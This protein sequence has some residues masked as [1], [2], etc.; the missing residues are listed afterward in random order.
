MAAYRKAKGHGWL[1][2]LMFAIGLGVGIAFAT[3]LPNDSG[4]WPFV[5][6]SLSIL[7]G[8]IA[9]AVMQSRIDKNRR[10]SLCSVLQGLGMTALISPSPQE[11]A[12][13]F[14]QL[15]HLETTAG[16]QSGSA[17]LQWIAYGTIG[18][19]VA[20]AFEHEYL[21]GSGEYTQTHIATCIAWVGAP[22][23]LTLIRPR[24]GEGRAL[25]R[26]HEEIRL[27]DEKFDK[28]WIIWG[29]PEAATQVLTPYFR[30]RLADSPRG[31]MW[32]IGGGWS[33]CLFKYEM[34]AQNLL[35]FIE[36]SG[37]IVFPVQQ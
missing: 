37:Q 35:K 27:T 31:E 12:T 14:D 13:F 4:A 23:W 9:A 2:V 8:V 22:G 30:Q 29:E 7:A 33:C 32:C 3:Q 20:L 15:A 26:A 1:W 17:N 36:R 21:T 18:T 24:V 16:L 5:A 6:M 28:D 10:A 34:D 11:K 25:E 19:K